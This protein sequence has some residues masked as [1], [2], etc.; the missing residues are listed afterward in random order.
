MVSTLRKPKIS[1]NLLA[2]KLTLGKTYG[3]AIAIAAS[4][5]VYKM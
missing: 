1:Q 3:N 2:S 4:A 5:A